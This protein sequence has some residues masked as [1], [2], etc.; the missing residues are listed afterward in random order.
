MLTPSRF[1][2]LCHANSSPAHVAGQSCCTDRRD[3]PGSRINM[4][5]GRTMVR[6]GRHRPLIRS[7]SW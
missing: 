6:A 4:D 1:Y 5:G 7:L 3:K 2:L